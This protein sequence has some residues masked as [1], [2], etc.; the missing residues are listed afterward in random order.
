[1]LTT[2][3][4]LAEDA[5]KVAA[6]PLWSLPDAEVIDCLRVVHR[7]EQTLSVWKARLAHEAAA[8]DVPAAQGH[9]SLRGWLRSVLLL[10]PAPARELAERAE[11]WHRF[12]RLAEALTDGTVDARQASVIAAAVA[13]IPANLRDVDA[14]V[15][16][17][18]AAAQAHG[19]AGAYQPADPL[20]ERALSALLEMAGQFSAHQLRG[21]GERILAHVAPDVADRAEEAALRRAEARAQRKR[22]FTLALPVDGL[23]RVSGLL[24]VEDAAIVRA[25]IEPLCTP[26]P[27]DD[28]TPGQ[29]RADA[30]IDV[31]R[32]ALRTTD[33]PEHGGEPPQVAVTVPLDVLTSAL[34]TGRLDNGD[35]LSPDTVRRMAC[36]ARIVPVVLGGAGQVLDAGR[37]RRL[38]TGALRRAL[39]VR[40]R[41]CS[42]PACDRPPRWCDSHHLH[43]WSDGGPTSLSNLVLVCRHHH[44]L[45]HDST[46]GW[47]A[48]LGA[49][50]LPEFLP[51]PWIDP[52]RRPR[53]NLYHLRT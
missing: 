7:L 37:A 24:P 39:V 19:D 12:P 5:A 43:H 28:R 9:R 30:L 40:D 31:C 4:G 35:R 13:A 48:R 41:G 8:R 18:E 15:P 17:S 23:V 26:I 38:A 16:P 50:G 53:R 29:R 1:M 46:G 52:A 47:Q 20:A 49:D 45:L 6:A 21:L 44:R 14:G 36:D 22:H 33:L 11:Q 27:G 34:R 25:A 42:F 10:D 32:L 2:T 51:P 3:L